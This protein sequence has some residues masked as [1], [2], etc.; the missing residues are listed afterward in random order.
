M[1]IIFLNS[2][3]GILT[4]A[5]ILPIILACASNTAPTPGGH[6][7][8][9]RPLPGNHFEKPIQWGQI[10]VHLDVPGLDQYRKEAAKTKDP[11]A[12]IALDRR[13]AQEIAIVADRVL[14]K[15]QP[16][17]TTLIHRYQTLPLMVLRATPEA[18]AMLK[19]MPEVLDIKTDHT[20][21]PSP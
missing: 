10:I 18:E 9:V 8:E 13:M 16:T 21:P 3:K 14:K 2:L 12:A 17:G 6:A 19:T 7:K 15:L 1:T 20:V 5:A 11:E 4:V